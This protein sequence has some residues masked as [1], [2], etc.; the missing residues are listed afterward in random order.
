M[1]QWAGS[2]WYYLR[3]LDPKNDKAIADPELIKHWLPV[4]LYIGGAEHAVGHL[5]YARFWHK[6]LYDEGVVYTPEPFKKLFPP[7]NDSW[8]KRRKKCRNHEEMSLIRM[9]LLRS[10]VLIH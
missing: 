3:Y 8:G 5:L 2:C 4:D 6:F 9:I 7:R 1:P 10:T